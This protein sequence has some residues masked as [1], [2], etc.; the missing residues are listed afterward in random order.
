MKSYKGDCKRCR[1]EKLLNIKWNF[2]CEDCWDELQKN[3]KKVSSII[4]KKMKQ[5]I[6]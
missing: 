4:D 2:F 1:E 3:Y 6:K 5:F